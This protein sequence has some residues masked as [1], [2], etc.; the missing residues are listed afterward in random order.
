MLNSSRET[1]KEERQC[2]S[3]DGAVCL[4]GIF[5]L[6][7]IAQLARGLD[8]HMTAPSQNAAENN[9]PGEPGRFWDD[10]CNWQRVPEY[11]DFLMRSPCA[12]IAGELMQSTTARLFHDHVLV[13]EPGTA[14]ATPWHQDAPYYIVDG[15]QTCSLQ[16]P[17]DPVDED[18]AVQFVAGSHKGGQ[19]FNPVTW[20]AADYDYSA[21]SLPPMPNIDDT[22]HRLLR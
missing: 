5:D 14:K 7:W 21:S 3:E 10:L 15:E 19:L 12:R 20:S 1:S 8:R 13:K 4:R 6:D 2:F 11:R 17:L 9:V 16:I 18:V 22:T